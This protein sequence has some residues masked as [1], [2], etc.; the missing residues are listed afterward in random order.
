MDGGI[1]MLRI[2][3]NVIK[4]KKVAILLIGI[5]VSLILAGGKFAS[6]DIA[7]RHGD[8]LFIRT[9]QVNTGDDA[10][11][12]KNEFDY[13][14]F[15]E[16]PAN[17][18]QFIAAIDHD[19]F[20][21]TSVDSAWNRKSRYEQIEWLKNKIKVGS[22]KNNVIEVSVHFDANVTRNV[23]YMNEHGK[24]LA[25]TFI[26]QSEE[27][28]KSINPNA[29]FR[30]VNEEQS[31]PMVEPINRKNVMIKFAIIGFVVGLFGAIAAF[32]IREV[33]KQNKE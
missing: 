25:D 1:L 31:L 23:D 5:I 4:Q 30:V 32:F 16:S 27:S 11:N 17:Y 33:A 9:I 3:M 19:T 28:I 24:M 10:I 18:S 12:S 22:Y 21:F 6:S 2:L 8:Y 14:G 29:T 20:D 7:Q 15:L 13:K 26:K